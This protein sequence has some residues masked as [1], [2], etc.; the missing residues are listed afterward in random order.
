MTGPAG[1]E[2][3]CGKGHIFLRDDGT[4]KTVREIKADTEEFFGPSFMC[5]FGDPCPHED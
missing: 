5:K 4:G 3:E 1:I 2:I